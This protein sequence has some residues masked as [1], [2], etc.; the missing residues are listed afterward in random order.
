MQLKKDVLF[1]CQFFYPE[2]IS[3]AT[4]P[5]DTAKALV[6]AGFSVGVMCG[7]PK[8]YCI[9]NNEVL[10]EEDHK[11]IKIKRLKYLQVARNNIAGRLI[12]YFSFTFSV[13]LKIKQFKNYKSVIVYTNPPILP[14]V[15]LIANKIYKIKFILVSFDVYPEIAII[16]KVIKEKSFICKIMRLINNL[17][18]KNIDKVV[19]ISNDMKEF[20]LKNRKNLSENNI[21]VIPNW[22][23]DQPAANTD[24]S[25][26]NNLFKQ[27]PPNGKLVVSYFGNMGI[28]QDLETL[29]N[30][31]RY[32][33]DD[34]KIVF[35]FAGHGTKLP[36]FKKVVD[37]E[38]LSNVF[39]YDYLH[40]DDYK[41]AL[42][43]SDVFIV[44]LEEGLTGL[45]VPSKTYSYM[46]AGKPIVAIMG[47]DSDI[48]KDLN[49]NNA[50]FGI[51]IGNVTGLIEAIDSCKRDSEK[52]L[53]MGENAR[54]LFEEKYNT[55]KC[56]LQ[57]VN[58][59][60]NLLE[61]HSNV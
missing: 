51:E 37:D 16:T 5:F 36:F 46:M 40:G 12:N 15:A 53:L 48:I 50:G 42:N 25:Q 4:L 60:R 38:S 49:A 33:K 7:Y 14:F 55:Q 19:A 61:E 26:S 10:F 59:I 54:R 45:A 31:I 27:I 32:F 3:S 29:L 1:L 8:E 39:I 52:R 43:I 23:E 58:L 6:E 47:M 24:R 18:F 22:H 41:D 57:Y 56:T 30:A 11:G 9:S 35:L 21:A 44:S 13:L 28:A 20:L 2:Y 17:V 34:D